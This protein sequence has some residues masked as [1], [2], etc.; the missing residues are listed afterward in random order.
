MSDKG[1]FE[2]KAGLIVPGDYHR[3]HEAMLTLQR[4]LTAREDSR[5]AEIQVREARQALNVTMREL[6][7]VGSPQADFGRMSD[8][9]N[10]ASQLV[11]RAILARDPINMAQPR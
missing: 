9:L 3:L 1:H 10:S 11:S 2:D 8:L 6:A 4:Q 5:V 7:R